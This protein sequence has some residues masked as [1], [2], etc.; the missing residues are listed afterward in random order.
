MSYDLP[1][2]PSWPYPPVIDRG[3]Y[4]PNRDPLD[5]QVRWLMPSAEDYLRVPVGVTR[6]SEP[7]LLDLRW[8]GPHILCTGGDRA[9]FVRTVLVRLA[10]QFSPDVVQ[11]LVTDFDDALDP[12]AFVPH[13][14][15]AAIGLDTRPEPASRL[16]R[17]I[18][19]ELWRRATLSEHDL[20]WAP[21]LVLAFADVDRLLAQQP[22][23]RDVL[24]TVARDGGR[25]GMYLLMSAADPAGLP[26]LLVSVVDG[27]GTLGDQRFR[28]AA[29]SRDKLAE[30]S[31]TFSFYSHPVRP[32]WTPPDVLTYD[33]M[34]ACDQ[35]G[36]GIPVGVLD[37]GV[38]TT[39]RLDFTKQSHLLVRAD[40]GCG[41]TTTLR[42]L[43]RGL[44]ATDAVVLDLVQLAPV[45]D[46]LRTLLLRRLAAPEAWTG[47]ELFIIADDY[48][49]VARD[50]DPVE[51]LADL[52]HYGSSIGVHLV[53]TTDG[54]VGDRPAVKALV[55]TLALLLADPENPANRWETPESRY[56][57]RRDVP[58]PR[59]LGRAHVGST[60]RSV[61]IALDTAPPPLRFRPVEDLFTE[62]NPADPLFAVIGTMDGDVPV[63]LDV[64]RHVWCGGDFGMGK[65]TMLRRVAFSLA[66]RHS[67]ATVQFLV[68]GRLDDVARLPHTAGQVSDAQGLAALL[69]DELRRRL[70]LAQEAVRPPQLVILVDGASDFV[71]AGEALRR[72][73]SVGER[74]GMSLV[75][76]D[77]VSTDLHPMVSVR[78]TLPYVNENGEAATL[79][80]PRITSRRHAGPGA[81]YVREGDGR[82]RSFTLTGVTPSDVRGALYATP[83][84]VRAQPLRP[85]LGLLTRDELALLAPAGGV[86]LGLDGQQP[87]TVDFDR[88]RHLVVTGPPGSGRSTVLRT[89]LR[90]VADRYT[91]RDCAVLLLHDNMIGGVLPADHVL[92]TAPGF[93]PTMLDEVLTALRK[94]VDNPQWTGPRLFAAIDDLDRFPPEHDPLTALREILPHASGI[95][96]H[97]LVT[98]GPGLLARPDI[99]ALGASGLALPDGPLLESTTGDVPPL[100]AVGHGV[101]TPG[102]RRVSLPWYQVTSGRV[103]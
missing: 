54:D 4:A 85:P 21:A 28:L 93:A 11:L 70:R 75:L 49:K 83:S 76:A 103:R 25:L 64:R 46:R 1:P 87:V 14:A 40:R 72:V 95:G 86:L 34:M 73:I 26:G 5:P 78:V 65:T 20:A 68:A 16:A 37:D 66:D 44:A 24:A 84:P 9:A 89:L 18:D 56:G 60:G 42:T 13:T 82:P 52:L 57:M 81:G 79:G 41:K 94:R 17:A 19:W 90:G 88:E 58:L 27:Y 97:F 22:E 2:E 59:P 45:V 12:M 91:A 30:F 50:A 8:H 15:T 35:G 71:A 43:L 100:P 62:E 77:R 36:D 102:D 47:P 98:G 51:P 63:K 29:I 74:V 67:P 39:L 38:F 99:A 69:D 23:L 33:R 80:V 53:V 3:P 55:D 10:D 101:L 92:D 6:K 96:L 61:Q 48:D 32:L 7:V 31:Y